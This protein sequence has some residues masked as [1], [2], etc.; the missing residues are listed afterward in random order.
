MIR[1][2]INHW[3]LLTKWNKYRV[4]IDLSSQINLPSLL[5]TLEIILTKLIFYYLYNSYT[6]FLHSSEIPLS[7]LYNI[8][9]NENK[10]ERKER[11]NK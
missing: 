8:D 7:K 1:L 5:S 10:A 11:E 3:R 9:I 2:I 6:V 4:S